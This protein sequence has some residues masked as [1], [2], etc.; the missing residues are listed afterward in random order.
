MQHSKNSRPSV[1]ASLS[2]TKP[3]G[4]G[5][6]NS[7]SS[8]PIRS[9][10]GSRGLATNGIWM[11][12]CS[13]LPVN[14]SAPPSLERPL[15]VAVEQTRGTV[16]QL[17]AHF[18]LERQLADC[19]TCARLYRPSR[20]ASR[21]HPRGKP[22][23]LTYESGFDGETDSPLEEERFELP[24]PPKTECFF[25]TAFFHP[26]GR[27]LVRLYPAIPLPRGTGDSNP[28]FSSAESA[29]RLY[30]QSFSQPARWDYARLWRRDRRA[31]AQGLAPQDVKAGRQPWTSSV[32]VDRWA[33]RQ[34]R[35]R[36]R[37]AFAPLPGVGASRRSV[38]SL[39]ARDRVR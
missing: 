28:S 15:L 26:S 24:V 7:A 27:D 4:N 32:Q 8:S 38:P 17:T 3:R 37:A 33:K 34:P 35:P 11:R 36:W 9:V 16:D 21:A 10:V 19:G 20:Q 25:R 1:A 2:A 39:R 6:A 13:R 14:A 22:G 23:F 5:R 30:P 31:V 18:I 12:S 29:T